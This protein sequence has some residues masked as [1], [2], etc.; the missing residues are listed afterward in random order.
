MAFRVFDS[1]SGV[2]LARAAQIQS[3]LQVAGAEP[4]V[5]EYSLAPGAVIADALIAAIKGCDLFVLLW[6]ARA[7]SSEWVPL[8]VG[9]ARSEGKPIIPVLM[10]PGLSLPPFLQSVKYLPLHADPN[11]ALAWLQQNVAG[12]ARDK[13]NRQGLGWLAAI[14]AVFWIAGQ[15]RNG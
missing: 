4:Y 8:E 2:E 9:T 13:S 7:K 10:Q 11:A 14:G 3:V 15:S 12:L 6:S 5:A 1:Y